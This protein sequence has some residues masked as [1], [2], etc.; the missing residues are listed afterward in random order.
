M[1]PPVIRW[2]PA[3]VESS[4]PLEVVAGFARECAGAPADNGRSRDV[5]VPTIPAMAPR[6]QPAGDTPINVEEFKPRLERARQYSKDN[7][8]KVMMCSD[9]GPAGFELVQALITVVERQQ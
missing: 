8:G 7:S 1:R 2:F 3:R 6:T 9:R 5:A 4:A